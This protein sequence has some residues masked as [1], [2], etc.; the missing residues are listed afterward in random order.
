MNVGTSVVHG[1]VL[2]A[3]VALTKLLGHC[4]VCCY[5][6]SWLAVL[7][8]WPI[9]GWGDICRSWRGRSRIILLWLLVLL[10]Q[11]RKLSVEWKVLFY[12]CLCVDQA[13]KLDCWISTFFSF[14]QRL[15]FYSAHR[16]THLIQSRSDLGDS[17]W[18]GH[19]MELLCYA[20]FIVCSVNTG[21]VR[22]WAWYLSGQW[23]YGTLNSVAPQR[24]PWP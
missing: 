24:A 2:A 21:L 4:I 12:H 20:N 5:W 13:N 19:T 6:W 16:E 10:V 1:P 15:S 8:C 11:Y 14:R 23:L 17:K 9:V 18:W 22:I 7:G 3:V